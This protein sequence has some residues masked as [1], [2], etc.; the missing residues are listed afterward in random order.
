M[1]SFELTTGTAAETQF[2]T[3]ILPEALTT[4]Q[5]F[6]SI[7]FST[8][9]YIVP[10]RIRITIDTNATPQHSG[11]LRLWYD[12]F[13]QYMDTA[14]EP[15][16]YTGRP[17]P[18]IPTIYTTSGQPHVDLQVCDSNP[19]HLIVP[20][21]HPQKCLSTNSVDPITNMGV[22]KVMV[23][24]PLMATPTS[25][26]TITVQM[27]LS[28]DEVELSL[29]IWPH[30]PVIPAHAEMQGSVTPAVPTVGIS[31]DSP[32]VAPGS[33][34]DPSDP[35][36]EQ[37]FV[38]VSADS[39]G[40]YGPPRQSAQRAWWE[41]GLSLAG[42]VAGTI[43]NGITGN[44]GGAVSSGINTLKDL[45]MDKPPDPMRATQNMIFPIAPL[46]HTQG[47]APYVRLDAA[48]MGGQT[49]NSFSCFGPEELKFANIM[50]VPMMFT[51]FNW[52]DSQ[53]PGAVL[54]TFP[55]TPALCQYANIT[56]N[57]NNAA[58]VPV[59]ATY[60]RTYSTFLRSIS[61][62]FRFWSGSL[63][64]RFQ[65]VPSA[66]HT[67][68]LYCTY[69]PNDYSGRGSETFAQA[70][71]AN[72]KIFDVAGQK[73][74]SF[75]PEWSSTIPRKSWY[76]WAQVNYDQTDDR[77]I[78]GWIT[79][80]VATRL[81]ITNAVSSSIPCNVWVCS[82]DNFFCESLMHDPFLFPEK[83][84][85]NTNYPPALAT[86]AEMQ[87]D[88][89]EFSPQGGTEPVNSNFSVQPCQ[90]TNQA[91]GD[92]RDP[93]RRAG[94]QG[95]WSVRWLDTGDGYDT[96][97]VQIIVN[98]MYTMQAQ[99]I[100]IPEG[101]G[102][103]PASLNPQQDGLAMACQ[104][105]V[106]WSG[107]IDYSFVPISRDA[108]NLKA[109]FYPLLQDDIDRQPLIETNLGS[110]GSLASHMTCTGQQQALQ[111]TCPFTSNYS[112]CAIQSVRTYP[113]EVFST[114]VLILTG[115]RAH[116]ESET[117]QLYHFETYR[118]AADDFR[119]SWLVAP[120]TE[121]SLVSIP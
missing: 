62:R 107:G 113:E 60:N 38:K 45:F 71:N 48:P 63:T 76:D 18:K 77:T 89:P 61:S 73:E 17:T 104:S 31:S 118:T 102:I 72:S 85:V 16:A 51:Q 93:C 1:G 52:S 110:Y 14:T 3:Q 92:V 80:R 26:S 7:Q 58:N 65:F 109:T 33:I 34:S 46:A 29:P 11:L 12:P 66:I 116:V 9:T 91:V 25:S 42:G 5:T 50:K 40:E 39:Q 15:P 20:F 32:S 21:E 53:A 120:G 90:M 74:F 78:M 24:N 54:A 56:D 94:Y 23:I 115:L 100:N 82:A 49:D 68:K 83:F 86:P 4:L 99:L 95:I 70:T 84:V 101:F 114:G 87:G 22:V 57:A 119:F 35:H 55:V 103:G 97:T 47:V 41:K 43:W 67:G 117:P 69:V 106:F 44:W 27:Y 13:N 96:F 75:T 28:F 6:H 88:E 10:K 30:T 2:L 111:V 37:G 64:F 81:T 59:P 112:Q 8:Y 19:I 121:R 105:Y 36:A 98:P 79:V 108:V